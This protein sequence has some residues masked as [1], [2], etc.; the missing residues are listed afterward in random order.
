MGEICPNRVTGNNLKKRNSQ[1]E[2]HVTDTLWVRVLQLSTLLQRDTTKRLRIVSYVVVVKQSVDGHR[3]SSKVIK[4][5]A[6]YSNAPRS[7]ELRWVFYRTC[8]WHILMRFHFIT[9]ITW[10]YPLILI[11]SSFQLLP[12]FQF[13]L[14][15]TIIWISL[16]T[17]DCENLRTL[18]KM[19]IPRT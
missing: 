12:S 1:I 11:N 17:S 16:L 18:P 3:Y 5:S 9:I 19:N 14:T 13:V 8:G 2:R 15:Q 7:C 4:S 6:V 10:N